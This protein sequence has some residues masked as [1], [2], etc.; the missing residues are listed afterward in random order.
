MN[1]DERVCAQPSCGSAAPNPATLVLPKTEEYWVDCPSPPGRLEEQ[2]G[3]IWVCWG[4]VNCIVMD[5][6]YLNLNHHSFK[7][8][9]PYLAPWYWF[10]FILDI[11][12]DHSNYIT[13]SY[14][15][16][17][18][19]VNPHLHWMPVEAAEAQRSSNDLQC[20]E[21]LQ[22]TA[23]VFRDKTCSF[24]NQLFEDTKNDTTTVGVGE[25]LEVLAN[26]FRFYFY[27]QIKSS[28]NVCW[29][30]KHQNEMQQ[31]QTQSESVHARTVDFSPSACCTVKTWDPGED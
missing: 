18:N 22:E 6:Y 29:I 16:Y 9:K 14:C 11:V 15:K 5:S 13:I 25:D 19:K 2:N 28:I 12:L 23:G 24:S 1:I 17:G 8:I 21:N 31:L 26:T 27:A 20:W 3:M 4:T 10:R 7:M 30:F